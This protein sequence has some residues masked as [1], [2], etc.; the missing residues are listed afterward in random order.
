MNAD[1]SRDEPCPCCLGSGSGI[2]NAL[3]P[4][5]TCEACEGTGLR[6]V[7]WTTLS[8]DLERTSAGAVIQRGRA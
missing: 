8:L 6:V 2:Y 5:S 1:L 7:R 4:K 3:S